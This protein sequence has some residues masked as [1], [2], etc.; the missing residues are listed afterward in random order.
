LIGSGR[1]DKGELRDR[2]P[3][4]R[5]ITLNS[6]VLE[7][8]QV[9]IVDGARCGTG[10]DLNDIAGDQATCGQCGMQAGK[11]GHIIDAAT[12]G[13]HEAVIEQGAFLKGFELE[14]RARAR[15]ASTVLDHDG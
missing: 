15:R 10:F 9:G 3:V 7:R 5:R 8:G 2:E 1:I 4:G 11:A 6:E 12:G 14:K 13:D